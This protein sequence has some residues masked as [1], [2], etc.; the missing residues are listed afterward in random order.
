MNNTFA[1]A[2]RSL[3]AA[4]LALAAWAAVPLAHGAPEAGKDWVGTWGT[5]PADAAPKTLQ[6]FTNQTVRLIVRTSAG[7]SQV[8][9][10][11]SNELGSVPLRVGAAHVALRAN[12]AAIDAAS[13]R[14][15]TFGGRPSVVIPP[16]AP[17]LSDPVDLAVP[18]QS[19]LAV[20]L[21]LPGQAKATTVH[22]AAY[23]TSYVSGPGNF[24]GAAAFPTRATIA[25]WPF[26]TEVDVMAGG[27][28]IVALG[29]S[30]TDG[31]I[32]TANANRRW[33]DLLA[34]RLPAG[35]QMGV[36]NRG[37]GGNRLL[38]DPEGW[39]PFGR[40][41]LARFDRDVLATAGARHLVL[42]IGIND[43]GHPKAADVPP[44]EELIAGYRQVIARAR[45]HGIAVHGATL[46]PFE[47]TV[48]PGY[49]TPAKEAV[50]QAVNRWIRDSREFDS[51]IDF[52]RALRDP[53]RPARLLVKYDS[54]D[55]LHPNDA[56]MAAMADA[57]PL[58]LFNGAQAAPR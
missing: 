12:G 28:A 52:D 38:R 16:G 24:A 18:A 53:A 17:M 50:R 45:T 14:A 15:L 3:L 40:A 33:P 43:I 23:Q 29:D 48:F 22:E 57:V 34:R 44:A 54:G 20:S 35:A 10:R 32:T 11:L 21:Y 56:G 2:R 27:G 51:V 55:H 36:V 47:G 41:V 4:A 8:R 1:P 7:G 42:L 39:P 30:I 5:A 58:E 46:T 31:A 6:T 9:I 26:L 37:I 19:D 25:S 13:G 49:Y